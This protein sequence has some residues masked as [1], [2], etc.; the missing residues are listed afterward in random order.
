MFTMLAALHG[1]Q[2]DRMG[3][4]GPV[5]AQ[6]V[7]RALAKIKLGMR[8]A[9]RSVGDTDAMTK[10]GSVRLSALGGA[11]TQRLTESWLGW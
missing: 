9:E 4:F 8:M 3:R 10:S 11:R 5:T 2:A 6:C 7:E 1:R